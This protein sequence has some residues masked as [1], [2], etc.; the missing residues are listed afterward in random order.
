MVYLSGSAKDIL[1][2]SMAQYK[3]VTVSSTDV[4]CGHNKLSWTLAIKVGISQSSGSSK[5]IFAG[6]LGSHNLMV[7]PWGHIKIS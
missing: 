5:D 3:M 7:D 1:A 6:S 4:I 2:G